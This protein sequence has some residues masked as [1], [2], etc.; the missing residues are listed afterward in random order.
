MVSKPKQLVATIFN[1]L[2]IMYGLEKNANLQPMLLNTPLKTLQCT[3]S[4]RET[5]GERERNGEGKR[6]ERRK[7]KDKGGR[8]ME[9]EREGGEEEEREGGEEEEMVGE[10]E[11]MSE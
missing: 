3:S 5:E 2:F 4:E 10:K 7:G 6:E 9:R 8:D 1:D 11:R